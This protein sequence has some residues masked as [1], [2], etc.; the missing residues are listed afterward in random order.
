MAKQK[1]LTIDSGEWLTNP[2]INSLPYEYKGIWVTMLCL[3][4]E[5]PTRGVLER[6]NGNAYKLK[7]IQ[8]L[9]KL[10]NGEP[11]ERF[12]ELGLLAINDNEAYYSPEIVK[13]ERISELRRTIG[14]KGGEITKTRTVTF[15]EVTPAPT[16]EPIVTDER[17]QEPTPPQPPKQEP[18]QD[19][20]KPAPQLALDLPNDEP[21]VE[22]PP[23]LTPKQKAKIEKSKKY[24]YAEFVTL[25]TEEYTKLVAEHT[26]QGAKRMIQ[27]L[28]NY[29]GQSGK[30]YKSD[31][32][33]ILNWVVQRYNE[34][35]YGRQYTAPNPNSGGNPPHNAGNANGTLPL[36]SPASQQSGYAKTQD[37]TQRF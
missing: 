23:E 10:P 2:T 33:A 28:D 3:L 35:T 26:E 20:K 27:I 37:Y 25:T 12:V 36:A 9:L 13:R 34:E 19:R 22:Q 14:R 18:P 32:R 5:S 16:D 6:E 15:T 11:I 30:K 31:Y 21:P 4:W 17:P 7:D 8:R 1:A 24:S 29:K